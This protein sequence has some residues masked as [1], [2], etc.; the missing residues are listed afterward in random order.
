MNYKRGFV[1]LICA[2]IVIF[3]FE[4]VWHGMLMKGAYMEVA[5]LWRSETDFQAHF[6]ALVLGQL[7]IALAFTGFYVSQI[8]INSV[9]T[10]AR[11][12]I[13]IGILSAGS[14]FIQ[15]AV[16]PL[17]T[18]ILWMWIIGGV[19]ELAIVGA[20]IGAIYKPADSTAVRDR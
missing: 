8:G 9:S 11:Y 3:V 12:G 19:V 20:I 17:S 7:I 4:F 13:A 10:G 6:W 1:A 18:K 5:G 14:N 2:F 15:F 16:Q